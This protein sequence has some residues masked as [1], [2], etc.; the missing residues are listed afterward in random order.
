[1]MRFEIRDTTDVRPE[2]VL[3]LFRTV[4]WAEERG[5]ESVGPALAG[6][7]LL[8]TGW[9]D[10]RCV[11]MVRV[12]SDG[13]YRAL[14]EDV[15]V[16]PDFQGQGLGRLMLDALLGHPKVRDLE[17][18]FLFTSKPGFYERFGF[19]STEHGMYRERLGA[20]R[21]ALPHHR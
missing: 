7:Y 2:A 19:K 9:H 21:A 12:L 20:S 14:V 16:H 18:V 15:I 11:G 1:M 6:T 17:A 13:V 8:I 4:D 10:G 5:L 3:A